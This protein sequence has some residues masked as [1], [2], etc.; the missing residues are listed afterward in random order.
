MELLENGVHGAVTTLWIDYESVE[1]IHLYL[2][3]DLK[4]EEEV[5]A[6]TT[7]TSGIPARHRPEGEILDF[8]HILGLFRVRCPRTHE[9]C[10]S[11][12]V[13]SE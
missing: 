7:P 12:T 13:N 5:L 9:R 3:A 11:F 2:Y 8:R 4:L 10:P 1:T 6:K